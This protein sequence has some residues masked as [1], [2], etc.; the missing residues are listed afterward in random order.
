MESGHKMIL[1]S[2]RNQQSLHPY[3][4]RAF[5]PEHQVLI[6]CFTDN[7]FK[8]IS[9]LSQVCKSMKFGSKLA[10]KQLFVNKFASNIK[11]P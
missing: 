9:I 10:W 4:M 3:L 5:E 2:R 8:T 7:A 11:V 1:S 6:A